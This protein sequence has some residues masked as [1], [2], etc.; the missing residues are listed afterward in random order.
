MFEQAKVQDE[1]GALLFI[2]LDHF[3]DINDSLGHAAGDW[4]LQQAANGSNL[5]NAKMMNWRVWVVMNLLHYYQLSC[6]PPQ[7][8]IMPCLA[9]QVIEAV[10]AILLL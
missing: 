3:K 7:A 6:N 9:E 4:V 2:D 5:F 8:E 1:V 10:S